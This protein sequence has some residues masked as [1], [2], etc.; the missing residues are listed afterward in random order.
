MGESGTGHGTERQPQS[1]LYR[2]RVLIAVNDSPESRAALEWAT[3]NLIREGDQVLLY[4][5]VKT[6][7]LIP[8]TTGMVPYLKVAPEMQR[9]HNA[10]AVHNATSLLRSCQ[11]FCISKKVF[12]KVEVGRCDQREAELLRKVEQNGITHLVMGTSQP[13]KFSLRPRKK[14][15]LTARI[16]QA[17]SCHVILVDEKQRSTFHAKVAMIQLGGP[18]FGNKESPTA[19]KERRES[20]DIPSEIVPAEAVVPASDAGALSFQHF[21]AEESLRRATSA[22]SFKTAPVEP[23]SS[24]SSASSRSLSEAADEALGADVSRPALRDT[25]RTISQDLDLFSLPDTNEYLDEKA[26]PKRPAVTGLFYGGRLTDVGESEGDSPRREGASTAG[27][28]V[29]PGFG[30]QQPVQ[31][32]SPS[33][34][35]SSAKSAAGSVQTQPFHSSLVAKDGFRDRRRKSRLAGRKEEAPL[36]PVSEPDSPTFV[37]DLPQTPTSIGDPAETASRQS[38]ESLNSP[39]SQALTRGACTPQG[40]APSLVRHVAQQ[41]ALIAELRQQVTLLKEINELRDWE[42]GHIAGQAEQLERAFLTEKRKREEAERRVKQ[43]VMEVAALKPWPSAR[44][45]KPCVH[46]FAIL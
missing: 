44:M 38:S 43:L 30:V 10:V 20:Q 24:A 28:D 22:D 17:A 46:L 19:G 3:E 45:F 6:P 32:A 12:A 26:S 4:H 16:C 15:G 37:G 25:P 40:S 1:P 35:Q 31:S 21:D 33:I 13:A 36:F 39:A 8:V 2:Y 18:R 11:R 9:A 42:L 23:A 41:E 5:L 7:K 14:P 34:R 27:G 29:Q